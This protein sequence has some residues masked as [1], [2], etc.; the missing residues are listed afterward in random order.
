MNKKI[1]KSYILLYRSIQDNFLFQNKPFC[2]TAAWI[3]LL[4]SVFWEDSDEPIQGQ[5]IKTKAGS[6]W[7]GKRELA[8]RWGWSRGRVYRFLSVLEARHMI[9][10]HAEPYGTL[11]KIVNYARY[12]RPDKQGSTTNGTHNDTQ[13]G[14]QDGTTVGTLIKELKE[15]KEPNKE[16]EEE[17]ETSFPEPDPE[18]GWHE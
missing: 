11:I 4:L 10:Q 2:Q 1:N 12:Q 7:F 8:E 17:K 3:D 9:E 13:S 6:R 16:K 18:D 15:L 5:T 14:T